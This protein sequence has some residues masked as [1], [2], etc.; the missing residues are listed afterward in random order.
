MKHCLIFSTVVFMLLSFSNLCAAGEATPQ[1]IVRKVNQ[2]CDLL[3][4]QGEEAFPTIGDKN[5]LF[6]WKDSYIFVLDLDGVTLVHFSPNLVGKNMLD[7][8]LKDY[9]GKYF[10]EEFV[11]IAKS[12][13]GY[14]WSTY[15]W[16]KPDD[17][18]LHRKT[19]FIRKVPG[20][21]LLV[22]AGVYDL[23]EEEAK[24]ATQDLLEA[25]KSEAP[26]PSNR[27]AASPSPSPAP[28]EGKTGET[29]SEEG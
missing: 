19:S 23:T 26:A 1:E 21:D 22:G 6:V 12:P 4:E 20:R 29:E 28:E 15:W 13:R 14:G 7:L 3:A 9:Y 27:P 2:A 8:K 18:T 17:R 5:G 25:L 24:E 16:S 11:E 10:I